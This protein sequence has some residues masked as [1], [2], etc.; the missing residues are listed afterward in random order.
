[1]AVCSQAVKAAYWPS[2]R[3]SAFSA[4]AIDTSYFTHVYYAFVMPDQNTYELVI[5]QPHDQMLLNFTA[6][7]HS[8]HPPVKAL[9]SIGGGGSNRTI[10][11]LMVSNSS[12][13]A[14]F[15]NS[16]I[17][18]ARMYGLDGLDLDW[19]FPQNQ[20]EMDNLGFLFAEWLATL[21]KEAKD[22]GRRR[23]LLTAAV[24]F[25]VDILLDGVKRTYRT[26]SI[27]RNLD[28]VS[29]M[30]F[31]YHGSWDTSVTGA[32]A[33]LYD[34]NGSN[35]TTSYGITSWINAGIPPWK[36]VMG[37]PLYG[38]TWQLK[39]PSIHGIG[40]PA[41]GVGPGDGIIVYSD[42]MDYN[43]QNNATMSY[44]GATVSAY[45]YAGTSWIGYDDA[46]SIIG[47]IKYG[48]REKNIRGYFF[49]ALGF[50]KEWTI[51]K[52]ASDAWVN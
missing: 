35:L 17:T 6:T 22:T 15:I 50:D 34:P 44:D 41:V 24:Y 25:S 8:K 42:L 18:I 7:M 16:T 9:L 37:L 28:W 5:T 1:S 32:H 3:S 2:G 51:S 40:A 31:D 46:T 43:V 52:Q 12:S 14:V 49:W 26:G 48:Q 47:K 10:F 29:P 33:A 4:S 19:E 21:R 38:R 27:R 20:E 13:R 11:A 45:S 36:V 23:L 30:C 39:D